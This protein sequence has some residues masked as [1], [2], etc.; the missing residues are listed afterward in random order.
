MKPKLPVILD[1]PGQTKNGLSQ[2]LK[3]YKP[4]SNLQPWSNSDKDK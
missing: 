4:S 1:V 3:H 2:F